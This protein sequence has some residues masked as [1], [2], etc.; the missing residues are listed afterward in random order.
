MLVVCLCGLCVFTHW[1]VALRHGCYFDFISEGT[2]IQTGHR[3]MWSP[4]KATQ[5]GQKG[6][7]LGDK[8][9]W[10]ETQASALRG[11]P[12]KNTESLLGKSCLLVTH[13]SQPSCW[14]WKG[15]EVK[16]SEKVNSFQKRVCKEKGTTWSLLKRRFSLGTRGSGFSQNND[17]RG[18]ISLDNI[19]PSDQK[20]FHTHQNNSVK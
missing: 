14:H 20:Y 6:T 4:A 16:A 17:C 12:T 8:P 15:A 18:R 2:E 9:P 19:Y 13:H 3:E 11:T 1:T 7:E 10:S 5:P